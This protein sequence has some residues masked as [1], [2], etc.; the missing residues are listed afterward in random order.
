MNRS[1]S[2]LIDTREKQP[3]ELEDPNIID[4][5]FLKLDTGDYTVRGLEDKICI[6]RKKSVNELAINIHQNRFKD[7]LERVR[8]FPHAYIIIEASLRD[9]IEYPKTADLPTKVKKKIRTNGTFLMNCLTRMEIEYGFNIIF[10]HDRY[11]SQKIA[12]SLMRE[13]VRKYE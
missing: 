13:I 2:V 8:E 12:I 6:D 11:Y 4:R 1:F 9:V 3:W 5:E 7:E 10:G